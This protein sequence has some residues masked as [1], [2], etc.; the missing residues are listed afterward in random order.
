MA[1]SHSRQTR[2]PR[3]KFFQP[4][5]EA[6]DEAEPQQPRGQAARPVPQ[7]RGRS[8]RQQQPGQEQVG[9]DA[10][11]GEEHAPLRQHQGAVR[12]V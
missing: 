6:G 3:I 11:Q 2:R 4:P 10:E 1:G 9:G 12:D 7:P 5:Q 8:R